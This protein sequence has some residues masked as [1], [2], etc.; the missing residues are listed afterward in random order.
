MKR[1]I[2][3]AMLALAPLGTAVAEDMG[4]HKGQVCVGRGAWYGGE[5]GPD[6]SLR[7]TYTVSYIE[8]TTDRGSLILYFPQFDPAPF[9]P[10]AVKA[11]LPRGFWTRVSPTEAYWAA[12]VVAVDATGATVGVLKLSGPV[13]PG[14]DCNEFIVVSN[15]EGFAPDAD[16]FKDPPLWGPVLLGTTVM[17]PMLPEARK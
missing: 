15:M 4:K 7:I 3:V 14:K 17:R 2:C 5:V 16:P 12:L 8:E 1:I 6:G 13:T 9:V 11:S 10:G